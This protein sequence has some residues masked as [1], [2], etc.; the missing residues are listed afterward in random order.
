MILDFRF[1]RITS[2][3]NCF[4][5]AMTTPTLKQKSRSHSK[6]PK[7]KNRQNKD[8]RGQSDSAKSNEIKDQNLNKDLIDQTDKDHDGLELKPRSDRRPEHPEIS[9]TEP[10][11][12][13]TEPRRNKA[14]IKISTIEPRTNPTEPRSNKA[15]MKISTTEPRIR[16]NTSAQKNRRQTKQTTVIE[17]KSRSEPI[18]ARNR[19]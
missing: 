14:T 12:D 19:L 16:M 8:G 15:T 17:K 13:P 2:L 11:K 4:P 7:T 5:P 9:T 10:P 6:T 18:A 3:I 1:T